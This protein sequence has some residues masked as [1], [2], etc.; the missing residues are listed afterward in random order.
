RPDTSAAAPASTRTS[1]HQTG[2]PCRQRG[3]PAT[4]PQEN[5]MNAADLDDL[6]DHYAQQLTNTG[7]LD[8]LLDAFLNGLGHMRG[9][10]LA[11]L[12][13]EQIEH[14]VMVNACVLDETAASTYEVLQQAA[15][16]LLD[17]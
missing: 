7:N 16:I 14:A 5:A 2:R 4:S 10:V 15:D 17:T 6:L 11:H 13:R 1:E 8:D 3:R 12:V 9:E